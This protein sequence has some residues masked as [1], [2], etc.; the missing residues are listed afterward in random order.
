MYRPSHYGVAAMTAR[1]TLAENL[2]TLMD[3]HH[4]YKSTLAIERGTSDA[5]CRVGKSTIDRALRG[6]T[7]LT[8]DYLEAIAGLYGLD[9]WQLMTPGLSPKNP[10]VLRSIGETEDKLYM[11]IADLAKQIAELQK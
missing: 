4:T 2:R 11:R 8:I 10:P 5:G 6:E 7:N 9:A 3:T 1:E